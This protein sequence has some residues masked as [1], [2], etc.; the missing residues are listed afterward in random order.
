MSDKHHPRSSRLRG[1][2]NVL[3]L[4]VLL[5]AADV[6]LAWWQ[7]SPTRTCAGL[8]WFGSEE[9][10]GFLGMSGLFLA[11]VGVMLGG[12]RHPATGLGL[13]LLVGGVLGTILMPDLAKSLCGFI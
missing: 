13:L 11:L 3:V 7:G 6:G 4:V 1:L 2:S 9:A 10:M 12:S 5:I 8:A